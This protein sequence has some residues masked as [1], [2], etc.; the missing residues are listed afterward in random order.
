MADQLFTDGD[1]IEHEGNKLECVLVQYRE[2]DGV[3][4]NFVYGFRLHSE[5]EAERA[6]QK[7]IEEDQA[8]AREEQNGE[9]PTDQPNPPQEGEVL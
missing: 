9:Q 1:T 7:Q 5:L 8:A 3:R 2:R 6:E 4:E